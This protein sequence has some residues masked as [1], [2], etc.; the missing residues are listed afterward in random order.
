MYN[1]SFDSNLSVSGLA[2]LIAGGVQYSNTPA[3]DTPESADNGLGTLIAGAVILCL[4]LLFAGELIDQLLT[5]FYILHIGIL[6][7]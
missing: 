4:G 3:S 7:E 1:P 5:Y 2:L 6:Y